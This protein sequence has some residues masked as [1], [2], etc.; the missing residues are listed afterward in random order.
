MPDPL[1]IAI[2][3]LTFLLAGAVKGVIGLGLPSVS[4]ALLTVAIDL[5]SAM[6]LLIAP[7]FVTNVWQA[8]RGGNARA[9]FVRTRTFLIAATPSV[10][11]GARVFEHLEPDLLSALLGLLLFAYAVLSLAGIRFQITARQQTPMAIVMGTGNG[12]LTGMTGSFVVPG[13]LYLQALGLP[14]DQLI[15]AMGM[16]FTTSTLA[17][18]LALH[19]HGLLPP[20]L[21]ALSVAAIVPAIIGM[22]IGQKIRLRLPEQLFRKVFFIALMTLAIYMVFS[23]SR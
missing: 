17:L 20:T 16:L 10:W 3:L 19:G 14:R 7:S 6:A 13:V 11:I 23:A 21:G 2:V 15:Q 1:I 5:P 12:I 18:A 4:L 8:A 9:I 22:R